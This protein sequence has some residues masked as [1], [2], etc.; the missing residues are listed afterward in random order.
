MFLS[1]LSDTLHVNVR[2]KERERERGRDSLLGRQ[3]YVHVRGNRER[4]GERERE[5]GREGLLHGQVCGN[6]GRGC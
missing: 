1:S 6:R 5:R 2:C 4:E 3:A